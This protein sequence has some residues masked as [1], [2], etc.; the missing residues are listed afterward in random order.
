MPYLCLMCNS[1]ADDEQCEVCGAPTK[2]CDQLYQLSVRYRCTIC[3]ALALKKIDSA[4]PDGLSL[5]HHAMVKC[6]LCAKPTMHTITVDGIIEKPNY[7]KYLELTYYREL[8]SK[9]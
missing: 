1:E 6:P 3:G 5:G 4:T 2:Q 9:E 8:R 7:E